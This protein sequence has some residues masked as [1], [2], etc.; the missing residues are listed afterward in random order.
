MKT[1][2]Q[3]LYESGQV[4]VPFP[5]QPFGPASEASTEIAAFDRVARLEFPGD[6]PMLS[7]EVVEWAA[8]QFAEIC[9]LLVARDLGVE[10]IAKVFAEKCPQPPSPET[11]YAVDLFFRRL[12]AL[13]DFVE[14]LSPGDPLV[15]YL[16]KFAAEWPLSTAGMKVTLSP[17]RLDAFLAHPGMLRLYVD[18]IIAAEDLSRIGQDPRV[19]AALRNAI[20][21]HPELCPKVAEALIQAAQ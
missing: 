16:G 11:D 4:S 7:H 9:R 14:R 13:A 12:P 1:F 5:G 19:D 8:V 15:E 6:A 18:R 20:G 21:A 2:L 3:Q 10:E 17:G